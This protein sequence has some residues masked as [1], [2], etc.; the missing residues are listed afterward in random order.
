MSDRKIINDALAMLKDGFPLSVVAKL[1]GV[2]VADIL[3]LDD[4]RALAK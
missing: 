2:K 4:E 1:L 3:H